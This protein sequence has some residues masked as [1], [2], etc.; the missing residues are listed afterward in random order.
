MLKFTEWLQDSK[1][2]E[3]AFLYKLYYN[4]NSFNEAY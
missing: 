2:M 1:L 3:M 4:L